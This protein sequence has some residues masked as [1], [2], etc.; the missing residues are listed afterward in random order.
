MVAKRLGIPVE[1]ILSWQK[2][3]HFNGLGDT[4]NRA[5]Y[6]HDFKRAKKAI[7]KVQTAELLKVPEKKKGLGGIDDIDALPMA[8]VMDYQERE[9]LKTRILKNKKFNDEFILIAEHKRRLEDLALVIRNHFEDMPSRAAASLG[10]A[11]MEKKI[12]EFCVKELDGLYKKV[13]NLNK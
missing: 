4:H 8:K 1:K 3:G 5:W 11:G 2:Q 9:A 6:F 12:H 10:D 13:E 7:E